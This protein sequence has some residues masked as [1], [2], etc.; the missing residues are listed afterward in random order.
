MHE[1]V[2]AVKEIGCKR[3][4]IDSLVGF[5]MALAPGFRADFRESLYRMIGALTRLGVTIV[6]TVE[7]EEDFTSLDLSNFT[8]SFLADDIVRL[9]YVSING[10]LRKMLMVVKM[11]RSEH[12]IDMR[13]YEITSKGLVIGEPL[14]GYRGLTSG[15]PGPWSVESGKKIPHREPTEA[16]GKRLDPP[17][18]ALQAQKANGMKS[19]MSDPE[20]QLREINEALLVS[21]VRQH[22][23]TEQA[24][25]TEAALRES[26]AKLQEHADELDRFNRVAVGRELRMIELK[27]EVDEV[28]Q[29]YGEAARYP[30]EFDKQVGIQRIGHGGAA[31]A[32]HASQ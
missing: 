28:C 5:E 1:I 6:S 24:Q 14:R 32:N 19:P 9:R 12:S 8:V 29:R 31:S 10:Q 11:R 7:V 4:V 23:L 26:H 17:W 16:P 27:K 20:R 22:E 30:L 2:D 15:I 3:L 13:E 25:K 18:Q 21:S